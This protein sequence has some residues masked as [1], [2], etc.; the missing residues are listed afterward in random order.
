MNTKPE[1]DHTSALAGDPP[2]GR[3]IVTYGR[4]LMALVI[5]RSLSEQGVEVIGCDSVDMTVLSFSKHVTSTFTHADFE[6]DEEAA[7]LDFAENIRKHAPD[8]DRPYVLIPAFRDARIFS[9]HRDRFEPMIQIAAPDWSSIEKIHPKDHFAK[10]LKDED[11]PGP[12]TRI[13]P[14]DSS[15]KD[16]PDGLEFPMIAKPADGVGG[17]GVSKID[18]AQE[19]ETYLKEADNRQPV[20]LQDLVDGV[21]YCMSIIADRGELIGAV[22]YRNI[23]QF[24]VDAGAGAV[25]ET[26][27]ARPFL[28]STRQLLKAT[29]WHGVG[30]IDYRWNGDHAVEPKMLEMN[31]RFWAGLHHSMEAGV[32]FPWLNFLLAAGRKIAPLADDVANVGLRTRTPGAWILSAAQDIAQNDEHLQQ[33]ADEWRKMKSSASSADILSMASHFMKSAGE[34][35]L[36]AGMVRSLGKKLESH[37]GLSSEFNSDSDPAVGLGVLFAVS[38]LMRHGE[39]PPEFKFE[40]GKRDE[41]APRGTKPVA[42]SDRFDP[43]A[44][45]IIG[46]TKP[47]EGDW[48]AYQAMKLAVHLAG[49]KAVKITAKAP[50]DPRSVDGLIFGGGADVFPE[51]YEG[52]AKQGYTYD[53]ARDDMEAS[54]AESAMRHDIPVLGVCRGMQMINVLGGGTLLPDLS[55]YKDEDYPTTFMRRIFYRKDIIIEPDSWLA[56]VADETRLEVNSIHTQAI[57]KVGDDF[58]ITAREANGLVQ[59]IEHTERSFFVGVQFHPEFLLHHAFARNIFKSLVEAAQERLIVRTEIENRDHATA[60]DNAFSAS[61]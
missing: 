8:D 6:E 4:S 13:L 22:A 35:A 20:L 29:N 2:A 14:A 59:A 42:L 44:R 57:E 41:D 37:K 58:R 61:V 53:I 17:R 7:L 46:I 3:A 27:D 28:A 24:P 39:L 30:E 34:A 56:G 10:F 25:R 60:W 48:M 16:V 38:H 50:R 45:P 33:A 12:G 5:A 51:R 18:D 43:D 1:S 54:W 31:P 26:I 11:L 36:G 47:E 32:D 9:R 19:L 55:H 23:T 52:A 40:A 21:D 49:G 15:I